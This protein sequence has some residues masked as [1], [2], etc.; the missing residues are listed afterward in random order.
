M[1]NK[2]EKL[3]HDFEGFQ[4]VY[5]EAPHLGKKTH[6]GVNVSIKGDKFIIETD[7]RTFVVHNADLDQ[8]LKKCTFGNK[9]E[10]KQYESAKKPSLKAEI[11]VPETCVNLS[12]GLMDMFNK[13]SS[14]KATKNDFEQA[15][16]MSD[17]AGKI[18]DVEKVKLG[19]LA[20]SKR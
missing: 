11:F 13:I 10:I 2:L 6:L 4:F 15:K 3:Q 12:D 8:F 17:I 19:Y 1:Q 14:G 5:Q 16:S 9:Q 20:L 7:S 18:I